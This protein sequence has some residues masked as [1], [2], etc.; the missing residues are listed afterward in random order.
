M[1]CIEFNRIKGEKPFDVNLDWFKN[2]LEDIKQ[3]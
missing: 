3:R 1:R 2:M